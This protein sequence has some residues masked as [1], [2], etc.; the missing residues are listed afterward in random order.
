MNKILLIC[1]ILG[2]IQVNCSD[3]TQSSGGNP[4]VEGTVEYFAPR[5]AIGGEAD[6][7]GFILRDYRWIS[8]QPAF[9][10][11]R[12]YA[13]GALDSSYLQ[14]RVQVTGK[15]ERITAGGV[16]TPKRTFLRMETER[17]QIIH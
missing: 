16:E 13:S 7:S 1:L 12:I 17:I 6:P 5:A 2:V 14:K 3:P 10:Y 15:V 8:G 11:S 9:S 4:C